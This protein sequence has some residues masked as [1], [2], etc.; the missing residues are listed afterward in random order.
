MV[1]FH[2]KEEV[3]ERLKVLSVM[4]QIVNTIYVDETCG[5]FEEKIF[6]KS[7]NSLIEKLEKHRY[8]LKSHRILTKFKENGTNLVISDITFGKTIDTNSKIC[9][10]ISKNINQIFISEL[11]NFK[12]I[13]KVEWKYFPSNFFSKIFFKKGPDDL[14]KNILEKSLGFS[15][16]MISNPIYNELKKSRIFEPIK[17]EEKSIVKKVGKIKEL[18]V[19]LNPEEKE[20]VIYFAN[21]DS[22]LLLLKKELELKFLPPIQF[23]DKRSYTIEY[24]FVEKGRTLQM[25]IN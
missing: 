15:W 23:S 17:D 13:E 5:F 22:I 25:K 8:K 2:S 14:V 21:Y 11:K 3:L 19:F 6:Q 4:N 18:D 10:S 1:S 20:M 16:I 24:L 7:G 9:E 12:N